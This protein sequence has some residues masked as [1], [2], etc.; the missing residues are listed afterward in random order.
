VKTEKATGTGYIATRVTAH[1]R[2]CRSALVSP[3]TGTA[4]VLCCRGGLRQRWL[5]GPVRRRCE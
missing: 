5:D 2:T 4:W 3:R 1:S